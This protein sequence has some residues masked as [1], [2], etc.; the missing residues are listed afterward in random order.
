M[1]EDEPVVNVIA[2]VLNTT[3]RLNPFPQPRF[4]KQ[5]RRAD[6][7][8]EDLV[9]RRRLREQ[10]ISKD[11]WIA[12]AC[13]STLLPAAASAVSEA[14]RLGRGDAL[15]ALP[16]FAEDVR[17]TRKSRAGSTMRDALAAWMHTPEGQ[18]WR[19]EKEALFPGTRG[20]APRGH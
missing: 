11:A 19:R 20:G 16:A 8:A 12:A 6:A 14:Q 9:V 3:K 10:P 17:T 1:V 15:A 7:D 2:L 5:P 18:E 13:P 4:A